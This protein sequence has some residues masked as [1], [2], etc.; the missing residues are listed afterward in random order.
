MSTRSVVS[1]A[2]SSNA[3]MCMY[4][5]VPVHVYLQYRIQCSCSVGIMFVI[6][7]TVI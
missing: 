6:I 5:C 7:A 2:R 1:T 3:L 4:M